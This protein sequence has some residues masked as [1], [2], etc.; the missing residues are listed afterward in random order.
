[1]ANRFQRQALLRKV[2]YLA[3]ILVL[4]TVSLLHRR[5]IV[6]PQAYNLQLREEAR[7]EVELTSSAV[8][9][10]TTGLRGWATCSLW[11]G[12]IE[13]QRKH[14]WNELELMVRSITKLQ[15][16]F[17]SP[18]LFQSWNLSFNV[19]VEC[20]RVKDK[21]FYITRG[22]ELLSEGERRNQGG[23]FLSPGESKRLRFP[24]NPEMRFYMGFTYQLKIGQGDEQDALRCLYDLSCID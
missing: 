5:L 24:G 22:L 7:G 18:W 13:K 12:A 3:L 15:P 1:M 14:E 6:I 10:A 16:Y 2:V 8:R 11:L 17:V 9:L 23:D 21:Y 4:L 19:A 20:D